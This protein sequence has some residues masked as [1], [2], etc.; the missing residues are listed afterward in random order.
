MESAHGALRRL[1]IRIR[2]LDANW[3]SY[4]SQSAIGSGGIRLL[5][6]SRRDLVRRN[7]EGVFSRWVDLIDREEWDG[8]RVH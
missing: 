8:S 7:G 4:I 2:N 1:K 3:N 6:A 5:N